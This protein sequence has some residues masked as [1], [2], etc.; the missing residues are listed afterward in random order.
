ML[1][2]PTMRDPIETD[3]TKTTI[4]VMVK[5]LAPLS[6]IAKEPQDP[7]RMPITYTMRQWLET[8]APP[9][10]LTPTTP[11]ETTIATETEPAQQMDG[12]KDSP[13]D[14]HQHPT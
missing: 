11:T 5:E 14:L 1:G 3:A 2:T 7:P 12:A 8:N 9:P 13:D 10:P 6:D 4:N